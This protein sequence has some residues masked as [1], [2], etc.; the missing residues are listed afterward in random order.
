M[1]EGGQRMMRA[2]SADAFA[3]IAAGDWIITANW[4]AL[5]TAE[6]VRTG[7]RGG[8]PSTWSRTTKPARRSG[9][10]VLK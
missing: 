10:K 6:S 1:W 5:E 2:S 8:A 4:E 3:N 7:A 9:L